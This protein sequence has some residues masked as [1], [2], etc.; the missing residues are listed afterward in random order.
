MRLSGRDFGIKELTED[1][2]RYKKEDVVT[3][4]K[5]KSDTKKASKSYNEMP[6]LNINGSVSS[7]K[8]SSYDDNGKKHT[9]HAEEDS[10]DMGDVNEQESNNTVSTN[11]QKRKLQDSMA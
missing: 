3:G 10:A 1:D 11:A 7:D 8:Q 5:R 2:P 9:A 4:G 6:V